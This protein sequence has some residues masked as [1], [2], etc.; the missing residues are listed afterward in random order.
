MQVNL[1]N[2]W[3]RCIIDNLFVLQLGSMEV[4]HCYAAL[5][6]ILAIL[7]CSNI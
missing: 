1:K 4:Q 2:M 6:T 3:H 7:I 5:L